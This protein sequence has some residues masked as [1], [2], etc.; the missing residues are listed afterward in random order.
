MADEL[1]PFTETSTHRESNVPTAVAQL[2]AHFGTGPQ[3]SIQ[4]KIAL[5]GAGFDVGTERG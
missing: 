2:A 1:R 3:A 4:A 5:R